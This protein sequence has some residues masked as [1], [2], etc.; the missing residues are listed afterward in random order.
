MKP[1]VTIITAAACCVLFS[2]ASCKKN[3]KTEAPSTPPSTTPTPQEVITTLRLYISDSI[4]GSPIPGSPFSFKDP[5]GDG[6]QPGA[7]LNNGSDSL[8]SLMANKVYKTRVVILDETK[9]PVD[10]T[11]NDIAGEEGFEHMFFY[12]GNPANSGN[13]NGNTI[14]KSGYPNYTVKLNAS[15]IV[16]RYTDADNGAAKGKPTRNIGL[17]TI[18]RTT[19]ATSVSLPFITTLRHQP[20]GAKDGTYAP[21]ETDAEVR[22]KVKV[23]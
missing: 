14:L 20:D 1:I 15:N 21:G 6:G 23:N 2:F 9:T 7:F 22:F 5:D 3:K 10:S 12:N 19:G 13:S 8:I 16:I 4:S 17:E 11:S 18:L